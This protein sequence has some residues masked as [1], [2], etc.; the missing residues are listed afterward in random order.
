M[1]KGCI[2]QKIDFSKMLAF[3][4]STYKLLF[5]K[6]SSRN[7]Q[8]FR[9]YEHFKLKNWDAHRATPKL[10]KRFS[11]NT[12]LIC[13]SHDIS[14]LGE[15]NWLKFWVKT[16]W[17]IPVCMTKPAIFEKLILKKDKNIFV[18]RFFASV[19]LFKL[20]PTLMSLLFPWDRALV[21]AERIPQ[22]SVQTQT[23]TIVI[24]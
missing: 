22:N 16:P 10:A 17:T 13:G 15:P 1:L 21:T 3:D 20:I 8:W 24:W 14:R 6:I 11:R 19:F 18:N 5:L 7:S 2:D 4:S 9:S 12:E 23:T